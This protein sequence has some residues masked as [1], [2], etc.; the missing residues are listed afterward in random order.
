MSQTH[1]KYFEK[2]KCLLI[3]GQGW[4]LTARVPNRAQLSSFINYHGFK[5]RN[6]ARW[7]KVGNILYA[8]LIRRTKETICSN[9]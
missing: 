8:N 4:T 9:R 3:N 5:L 1:A 7:K 2:A 6:A